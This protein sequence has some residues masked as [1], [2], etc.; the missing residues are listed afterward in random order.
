[1]SLSQKNKGNFNILAY[2]TR[3]DPV[4]SRDV[5]KLPAVG[6]GQENPSSLNSLSSAYAVKPWPLRILNFFGPGVWHMVW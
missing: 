4:L 3:A 1:M 6:A 5:G 2:L